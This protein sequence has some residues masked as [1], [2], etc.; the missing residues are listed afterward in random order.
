MIILRVYIFSVAFKSNA[1]KVI[2]LSVSA[3][4]H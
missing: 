1:E 4:I 2:F 3:H